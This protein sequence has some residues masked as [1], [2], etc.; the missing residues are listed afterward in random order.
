MHRAVAARLLFQHILLSQ[1]V[2]VDACDTASTVEA[3]AIRGTRHATSAIVVLLRDVLSEETRRA[4][5][6]PRT[7]ASVIE[8][9][10]ETGIPILP[11]D[12]LRARL[13]VQKVVS[14][15]GRWL[16]FSE[17]SARDPHS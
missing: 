5:K 9:V 7:K 14:C 11:R 3:Q 15:R 8:T 2:A 6:A 1:V 12:P 13:T 17:R 10:E 4:K 16:H